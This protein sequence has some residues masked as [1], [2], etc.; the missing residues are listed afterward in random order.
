M[1]GPDRFLEFLFDEIDRITTKRR[2]STRMLGCYE[3][4]L[5]AHLLEQ[6]WEYHCLKQQTRMHRLQPGSTNPGD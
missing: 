5:K 1:S 3:M 6:K 4:I 2:I